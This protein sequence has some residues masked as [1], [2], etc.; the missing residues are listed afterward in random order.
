[1]LYR[2]KGIVL[3]FIRYRE[4]SIIVKIYT[5]LF[6]IRSYIVNGVR[7]MKTS[8]IALYQPLNLVD[9]VVYENPKAEIQRIA[10][11]HLLIPYQT[12][13]FFPYKIS[14]SFFITEVLSKSLKEETGNTE[15]FEFL[16]DSLL[17]FDK[18]E[19]CANFH[20]QFLFK[21]SEFLGFAIHKASELQEQFARANYTFY[22]QEY[23]ET[24]EQLIHY[25]YETIIPLHGKARSDIAEYILLL[26]RLHLANFGELQSLKILK[27]LHQ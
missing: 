8:K 5:E 10:E 9:L 1:M 12:I 25:S 19:K 27:E 2:S 17:V 4:S 13:P 23:N 22:H 16:W 11:I 7:N 21:L 18:L 15:L 3:N 24:I 6:G 20:L 14:S 26:Y